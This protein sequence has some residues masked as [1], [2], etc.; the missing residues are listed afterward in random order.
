M[1]KYDVVLFYHASATYTVEA[2]DEEAA[3]EA[4]RLQAGGEPEEQLMERLVL[5][6][7]YGDEQVDETEEE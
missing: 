3:L 7:E 1:P 4:A 2:E 5:D 6:L